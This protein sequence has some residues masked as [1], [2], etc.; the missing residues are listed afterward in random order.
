MLNSPKEIAANYVGIGT[1]KAKL[2]K[3]KMF[4]LAIMAG[5]FIAFGGVA[6]TTAS[7][8]IEAAS[9]AKLVGACVFPGG[10]AMVLLAGSELFT[11]NC[12]LVIPLMEK[13]ITAAEMVISWIIV[14]LGN[15]VGGMLV[16][17]MM[18]YSHLGNLFGGAEAQA[19]VNTAVGKVSLGFGDALIRGIL[20]NILVCIAVWMSFAVKDAAGKVIAIFFPVMIFVLGGFEHCVANMY[21][22]SAGLFAKSVYALEAA[23]LTWA[24]FFVKNLLPVTIGNI[25]G[26]AGVGLVYWFAYLKG[27]NK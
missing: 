18:V 20:C 25:I 27:Q 14:W 9:V 19:M 24:A 6:C 3:A 11:G 5:M 7:V 17:A 8:S 21:F 12:L 23:D 13:K 2:D 26:G 1:G 15:L 22:I 16:A 4:V 10:L